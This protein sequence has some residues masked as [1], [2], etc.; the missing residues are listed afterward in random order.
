MEAA[1]KSVQRKLMK[2]CEKRYLVVTGM[3][4][5]IGMLRGNTYYPMSLVH[6][7]NENAA[8]IIADMAKEKQT[9]FYYFNINHTRIEVCKVVFSEHL[10]NL[11]NY[12]KD[13][14]EK[15]KRRRFCCSQYERS[16]YTSKQNVGKC[17]RPS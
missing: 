15:G 14:S 11:R 1:R 9:I 16:A 10:R 7:Q 6:L 2:K 3:R 12:S 5:K 13:G 8:N 4:H 17:S